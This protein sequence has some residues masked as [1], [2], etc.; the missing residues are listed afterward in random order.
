MS[1]TGNVASFLYLQ[2][3]GYNWIYNIIYI[4]P[5]GAFKSQLGGTYILSLLVYMVNVYCDYTSIYYVYIH[6]VN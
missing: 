3:Y 6:L 5:L 1:E 4:P 2:L